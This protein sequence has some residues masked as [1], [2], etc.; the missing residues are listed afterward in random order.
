MCSL[1]MKTK[2]CS[3]VTISL[4][5]ADSA[6][7]LWDLEKHEWGPEIGRLSEIEVFR[8][9]W[10]LSVE[11]CI[12]DYCWSLLADFQKH[13]LKWIVI[14]LWNEYK[15]VPVVMFY[16]GQEKIV[17]FPGIPE[18]F[19]ITSNRIQIFHSSTFFFD[20]KCAGF[21]NDMT[22]GAFCI[23]SVEAKAVSML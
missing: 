14:D 21:C 3:Q 12:M 9:G 13:S 10:L 7:L 20:N 16:L 8:N 22:H 5:K 6:D 18:T 1:Y 23:P 4:I 2:L 19:I 11:V 17:L 15:P